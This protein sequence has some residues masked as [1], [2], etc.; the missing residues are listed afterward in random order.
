MDCSVAQ[1]SR[2]CA[3]G[4]AVVSSLVSKGGHARLILV[5]IPMAFSVL[6]EER[7]GV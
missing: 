5:S 3:I 2:A 4:L 7:C 6:G 1:K